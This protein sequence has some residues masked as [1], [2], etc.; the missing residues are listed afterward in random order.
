M[1]AN[2][3]YG[4]PPPHLAQGQPHT[5]HPS[6]PHQAQQAYS[7]PGAPSPFQQGPP[8]QP[9]QQAGGY[10]GYQ[11]QGTPQAYQQQG[12]YGGYPQQSHGQYPQQTGYG[13]PPSPGYDHNAVPPGDASQEADGLRGA[14]KGFGTN[15]DVLIQILSRP[16]PLRMALIRTTYSR[17]FNRS[18]EEDIKKETS[19]SFRDGLLAIVRGP[20]VQDVENVYNAIKG[21]GTKESMLNDVLLGRSNADLRVIKQE[22]HK[23]FGHHLEADVKGDLSLK[24]E[25]LFSMVMA[26]TRS[27]E[28]APIV[29]QEIDRDVA[30]LYAATEGRVGAD[31]IT[32]CSIMASRSDGQ[33]RTIAQQFE[34][35]YHIKLEK[36]LEKEFSG[37]M[38]DALLLMLGRATDPSMTAAVQ[39]ED[40]MK[41]VG[42]RDTLLVNRVI[43]LHWNRAEMDQVKRAYAFRF[44]RDLITRIQGETSRHYQKLLVTV[45]A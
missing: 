10:G 28:S 12:S 41:G 44:K 5:I 18:L 32:V 42:T 23:R 40:T 20:L 16:D 17:R 27:E 8:P 4:G 19:G 24:T 38:Q 7:A 15:E 37:H 34:Q 22:Y 21:L 45:L 43:R 33:L 29:P 3:Y 31:Q 14:M 9:Y 30:N 2:Q 6:Y 11:Q 26:A 35:R 36:V 39:L 13:A 25:R 1:S